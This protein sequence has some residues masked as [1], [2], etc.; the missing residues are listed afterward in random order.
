[1][2]KVGRKCNRG[3][4]KDVCKP[5]TAGGDFRVAVEPT[6]L[7]YTPD[8]GLDGTHARRVPNWSIHPRAWEKGCGG[9]CTH[10][11]AMDGS[12]GLGE[13]TLGRGRVRIAGSL[14]PD[15]S[16]TPGGVVDMRFG[17]ADYALAFTGWQVFLNLAAT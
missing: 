3:L 16:Y 12:V 1:M 7:G 17:L 8:I 5:G 10:A 9:S 13:R 11:K 6:P 14:F 15:P 4:L 2:Y